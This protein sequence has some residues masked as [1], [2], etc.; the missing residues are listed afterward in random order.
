VDGGRGR[1]GRRLEWREVVC[2]EMKLH[3]LDVIRRLGLGFRHV[4]VII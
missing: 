4:V 3:L 1:E 2:G